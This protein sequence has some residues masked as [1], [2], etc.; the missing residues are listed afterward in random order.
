MWPKAGPARFQERQSVIREIEWQVCL[1]AIAARAP[2]R[3]LDVG[4]GNAFHLWKAR[5]L[6]FEVTGVDPVPGRRGVAFGKLEDWNI[7]LGSA[8]ELPFD[9]GSFDVVFSSHSLEH[10]ADRQQG[11]REMRRVLQSKG[12]AV[13]TVPT[14]T[15]A[16][17]NTLNHMLFATHA[18]LLKKLLGEPTIRWRHVFLPHAHGSRCRYA[19]AETR[20]F[21]VDAWRQR[22][23]EV[24]RIV[25]VRRGPLYPYPDFPQWFPR[26][27]LE[28]YSSSV[29]FLCTR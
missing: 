24:F 12:L 4:C 25:D 23:G 3:F 14:G 18:R 22:I 17:I 8:E 7:V 6:G 21:R 28:R 1:E 20:D 19:L 13:I 29:S 16:L 15:M 5:K 9:D 2:G 26:M 11:L 27:K 10:F